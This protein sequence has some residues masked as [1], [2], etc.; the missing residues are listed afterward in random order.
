VQ[1][2]LVE[3]TAQFTSLASNERCS[4]VEQKFPSV[5]NEMGSSVEHLC[6]YNTYD[7]RYHPTAGELLSSSGFTALP[8][9]IYVSMT[10][11]YNRGWVPRF[12]ATLMW[13]ICRSRAYYR[14]GDVLRKYAFRPAALLRCTGSR[15]SVSE[16]VC[17][18]YES[19]RVVVDMSTLYQVWYILIRSP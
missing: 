7:Y 9:W 13:I 12:L 16:L 2:S 6:V 11:S 18:S 3:F 10:C 5:E 1:G 8:V 4:S 19:I 17:H 14:L 15:S